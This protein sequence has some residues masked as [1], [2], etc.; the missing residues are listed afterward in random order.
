MKEAIK[1]YSVKDRIVYRAGRIK[2][3][4][5]EDTEEPP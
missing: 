3:P 1:K 5:D 4:R 2:V